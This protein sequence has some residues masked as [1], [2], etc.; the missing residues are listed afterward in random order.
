MERRRRWGIR[1]S[2]MEQEL[3]EEAC[4]FSLSSQVSGLWAKGSDKRISEVP[5]APRIILSYA[6]KELPSLNCFH[7]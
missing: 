7:S 4:T 6:P 1:E 5:F 2:A 3:G